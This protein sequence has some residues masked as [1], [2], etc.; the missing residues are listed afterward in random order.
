[1][2]GGDNG[3]LG[4]TGRCL[5]GSGFRVAESSYGA[6]AVLPMHSHARAHLCLVVSGEYRET[7][8]GSTEAR[9]PMT[10]IYYPPDCPHSEEHA[11]AGRHFL[12]EW[13]A[14]WSRRG[15]LHRSLP[16]RP[17][18]VDRPSAVFAALRA[19]RLLRTDERAEAR[20]LEENLVLA[21]GELVDVSGHARNR[22][23]SWLGTVFERLHDPFDERR[24][25]LDFADLVKVHRSHLARTFRRFTGCTLGQMRRRLQTRD[26]CRR[27]ANGSDALCH[28]AVD[29]GFSDQSHMTRAIQEATGF[30]PQALRAAG[31]H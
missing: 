9:G 25:L 3:F 16:S 10:L 19:F 4:H 20:E 8:R 26:A 13:D 29:S 17:T 5:E 1:M 2:R 18:A 31:S 22:P 30:T 12:V 28:V 15:D 6:G 14:E 21:L 24:G 11:K 27:L 23:P 7:L